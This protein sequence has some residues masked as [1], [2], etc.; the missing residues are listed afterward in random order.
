MC[1]LRS[2]NFCECTNGS[3]Y[4]LLEERLL[5]STGFEYGVA[6]LSNKIFLLPSCKRTEH[7]LDLTAV[8]FSPLSEESGTDVVLSKYDASSDSDDN[9]ESEFLVAKRLSNFGRVRLSDDSDCEDERYS[10]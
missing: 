10:I 6:T 3:S 1:A 9:S 7:S 5:Y 8:N 4:S 2:A